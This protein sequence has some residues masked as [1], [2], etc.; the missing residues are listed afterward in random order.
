[1]RKIILLTVAIFSI[2][3]LTA[4]YESSTTT[5][6][7]Q[8]AQTPP[9]TSSA[10]PQATPLQLPIIV[11]PHTTELRIQIDFADDDFL[12]SFDRVHELDYSLVRKARSGVDDGLSGGERLMIWANQP[13]RDFVV[14]LIGNDFIDNET[15]FIPIDSFGMV[16]ELKPSEAFVINNYF[17]L[18]TLPW[19]GVRFVDE[20]SVTR[21]FTFQQSMYD[22]SWGFREFENR[23][24]ELPDDWTPSESWWRNESTRVCA[25]FDVPAPSPVLRA[26][27][28]EEAGISEYGWQVAAEFLR[29]F[30]S[31]FAGVYRE[32][33]RWDES[34]RTVVPTGRFWRWGRMS[35][36]SITTYEPPKISFLQTSG[37]N[38]DRIG[39]FDQHGNRIEEAP[40]AYIQ[41][42]ESDWGG[43]PTVSYSYHYANYFKLFDFNNNGIPDIIIHFNQTF[44]GCYGGF[45]RI[46]R[47]VN[48]EYRMLEMAA[49]DAYGEETWVIFGTVN[50]LFVDADGKIISFIDSALSDMRYDHLVLSDTRA[51]FRTIISVGDN[52]EDWQEHHWTIW[53]H[54]QYSSSL[55]DSWIFHSPT[56]FMTD[57]PITHFLPFE[58]LGEELFVYLQYQRY[59][60]QE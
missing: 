39:F 36:Q 48:G 13:L 33:F 23:T 52:W 53:E 16:A 34:S 8:D 35:H 20:N 10:E 9:I 58:D 17:G 41:R 18:G 31:L 55:I 49:Y 22:G 14:L 42:F 56:I 30:D 4:C 1:M 19:S 27:L 47:Y 37:E 54:T 40:W 51:E 5:E 24:D 32:D 57:I 2:L 25:V 44:E 3:A 43:G 21:Y 60:A 38:W 50:D 12:S 7:M 6:Q 29:E 46:F 15:F 59:I 26:L 11:R 45:Y 28:L